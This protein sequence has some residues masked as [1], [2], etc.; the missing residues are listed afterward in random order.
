MRSVRL[1]KSRLRLSGSCFDVE[2]QKKPKNERAGL[3]FMVKSHTCHLAR[4][5]KTIVL[6]M[7]FLT[8]LLP[9][10]LA[11][12]GRSERYNQNQ[13]YPN[14][15][16]VQHNPIIELYLSSPAQSKQWKPP[17]HSTKFTF[18]NLK[19]HLRASQPLRLTIDKLISRTTSRLTF[20]EQTM[21]Q[22]SP[23]THSSMEKSLTDVFK[24]IQLE[25]QTLQQC[26]TA[27]TVFNYNEFQVRLA[28]I[29]L[30]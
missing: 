9:E 6:T 27:S 7:V 2:T 21:K 24:I 17:K 20:S 16:H 10:G 3:S 26:N 4:P 29:Q 14:S 13:P 11:H 28:Q 8:F 18:C 23:P 25:Y 12:S 1:L 15:K 5:A 30:N 19:D 22:H